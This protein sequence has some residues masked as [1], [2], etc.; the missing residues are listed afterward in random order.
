MWGWLSGG[1]ILA[2][3]VG[4]NVAA[5]IFATAVVSGMVRLSTASIL[6][7]IFILLG[8]LVNGPKA[9]D[10]LASFAA[11]DKL[12]DGFAAALASAVAMIGMTAVRL[13]VSAAQTAVGA[14]I[15]YQLFRHGSIG[16]SARILL[17]T[18]MF[19]WLCAPLFAALTA[20][21]IYKGLA[22]LS[23]SLPMPLFL[24]D[25][26]LR[27]G[28]V[29]AGCYGA[30]AFG[31]NNIA[32]VAGFYSRL[33]LFGAWQIGSL[34]ISG[35]RVLALA[36][37]LAFA[38]GLATLSHRIM[39]TVGRDLVKLDATSAMIAIFAQALVVD[40]FSHHWQFGA[41]E[42]A[43]VPVSISQALIGSILGLGFIRG[44]QTIQPAVL[45]KIIIGWILA[46]ALAGLAAYAILRLPT[47]LN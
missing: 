32:V 31:G 36:V 6:G 38:A 1:L 28:L 21:A 2:W 39:L 24:L 26:W 23:R 18:I 47:I 37:G 4:A 34:V 22:G 43:P 42:L 9:M 5:N 16:R 14:L 40:F 27:I 29:V 19:A 46:P 45:F 20:I 12:S 10:T 3:S 33:D 30:W 7:A 35:P 8:A 13:P 25:R 11:I 41:F 44:I 15:G 17:P